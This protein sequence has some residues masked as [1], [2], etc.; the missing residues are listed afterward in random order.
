MTNSE[1]KKRELAKRAID[2]LDGKEKG[3]FFMHYADEMT[4]AEIA[5]VL[6]ETPETV[7][8]ILKHVNLNLI[9]NM[10]SAGRC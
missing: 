3:V 5:A 4:N 2:A 7:G 1:K 10:A 9:A 6:D 8:Q